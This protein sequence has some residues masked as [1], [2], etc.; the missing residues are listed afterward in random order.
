VANK[1]R[2]HILIIAAILCA[3]LTLIIGLLVNVG[4]GKTLDQALLAGAALRS[5]HDNHTLIS[6]FQWIT[7]LGDS[8][9][10][11][12]MVALAAAWLFW[13]TRR[14]AAL[15]MLVVPILAGLT[16]SVLKEAF[17]RARPDIVP[18]LDSISNLAYPSGHA[19]NAMALFL[20]MALILAK[21]RVLTWRCAAI[22]LA[23]LIGLSRLTLGVHW[24]SDVIG[25]WLWG[26]AFALIGWWAVAKDRAVADSG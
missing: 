8:A 22:G 14:R 12:T 10:R 1:G 5:G 19:A 11:T 15:I 3:A 13:N 2:P 18:H 17:G 21:K 16:N 20:L 25:G 4:A 7:W 23:L 26:L 9:Q 24:P 6:L